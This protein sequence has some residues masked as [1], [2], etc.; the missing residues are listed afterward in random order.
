LLSCTKDPKDAQDPK[1]ALKQQLRHEAQGVTDRLQKE[2]QQLHEDG[3][4]FLSTLW[5]TNGSLFWKMINQWM[6]WASRFFDK[7]MAGGN[8]WVF[9][10]FIVGFADFGGDLSKKCAS[11][12]GRSCNT[13]RKAW[14]G[15]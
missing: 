15:R 14:T 6:E 4:D 5:P 13:S 8:P 7:H 12:D 3:W 1:E 11:R 10:W 2:K 9:C